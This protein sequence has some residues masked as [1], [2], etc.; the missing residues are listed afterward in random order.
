VGW[1]IVSFLLAVMSYFCIE[2]PFRNRTLITPKPFYISLVA[3]AALILSVT[4]FGDPVKIAQLSF[5]PE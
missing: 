1:I 4:L 3:V 2:Q 5:L